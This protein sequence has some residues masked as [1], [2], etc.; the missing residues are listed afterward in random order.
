MSTIHED[1]WNNQLKPATLQ[2]YLANDKAVIDSTA[3]INVDGYTVTVTPLAA[4]CCRGHLDVVKLLLDQKADPNAPSQDGCTPLYFATTH[5]P[6]PDRSS[7]V[8]ALISAGADVNLPCDDEMNV[9]LT[10]AITHIKDKEVVHLLV[11]NGALRTET[12]EALAMKHGM[13]R[14]LR[15]EAER[16]STHGRMVDIVVS[17][18]ELCVAYLNDSSFVK[19]V[20]EGIMQ[21]RSQQKFRTEPI[22]QTGTHLPGWLG[23]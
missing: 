11:D 6:P 20:V 8:Q 17:M 1:A 16:N 15:P 13:S 9:P 10:N 5:T 21:E 7:I 3:P 14:H 19:G 2:R 18:V 4:A 23:L 22:A 12:E